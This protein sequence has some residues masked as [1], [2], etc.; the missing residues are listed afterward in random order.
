[1]T[2]ITI[3]NI[4]DELYAHIKQSAIAH[5]RSINSE[6]IVGLE[7]VFQPSPVNTTAHIVAAREV[8]EA[9]A[10]YQF[11][12]DEIQAAKEEGRL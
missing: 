7:K 4:P 1:M 10:Q 9:L 2:S 8:R 12:P 5:R 3:K 11:D 6:L